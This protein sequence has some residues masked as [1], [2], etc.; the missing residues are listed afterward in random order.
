MK[1]FDDPNIILDA[2]LLMKKSLHSYKCDAETK[3]TFIIKLYKRIIEYMEIILKYC[4]IFKKNAEHF[5]PHPT[6]TFHNA[7]E[8]GQVRK[9]RI[10]LKDSLL[11][12]RSFELF[13]EMEKLASSVE[14]LY[15][16]H[17]GRPFI[18]NPE[19]WDDD[20]MDTLMVQV[21]GNFSHERVEHL[22]K[23]V[24]KLRPV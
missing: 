6:Q 9:I 12:D 17:N 24:R 11:T 22:K 4:K 1:I 2:L 15:D 5:K 16:K 8:Q 14:G 21:I 13:K 7:V 20:Y 23:V 3:D 10:M 18:E 19:E